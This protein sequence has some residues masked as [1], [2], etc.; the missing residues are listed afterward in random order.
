MYVYIT[1]II[2]SEPLKLIHFRIAFSLIKYY[3]YSFEFPLFP[4]IV[5]RIIWEELF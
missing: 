3:S 5:S 4:E 1:I 2:E